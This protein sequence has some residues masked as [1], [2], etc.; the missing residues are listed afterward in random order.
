MES[1]T[2]DRQAPDTASEVDPERLEAFLHR[3]VGDMAATAA[4]ALTLTGHRLGLFRAMAGAGPLTSEELAERTGLRE[5]YL[6]EWL[7]AQAAGAYVTYDAATGRYTLPPEQAAALADSDSPVFVAGGFDVLA[8]IW[9]A[10]ERMAEAFRTGEGVGWH[11]HDARLFNGTEAFFRPGYKANLASAWIPALEGVEEKLR[12]GAKVADVG[13]GHG[14]STIIMAEAFPASMFYGFDYHGPSIETAGRRA[15]DAG[16]ADRVR[17]EVAPATAFPGAGYDLIC[18]FDCFHDLGDP[19]GAAAHARKAL[20]ADGTLMLV[21]PMA[22]DRPEENLHPLGRLFYA[23]STFLCTPNSLSQEVGTA[24]GAQA[25][26]AR[27]RA[28]LEEAGF[29]RVRRATE[30]PFNLILEARP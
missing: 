17:F 7:N 3:A 24:L 12:A 6:R 9:A 28:I 21:E 2:I 5:R 15:S 16:V 14:A 20:A 13:C 26:E 4:C 29:R 18:F 19:V 8:A 23:A 11:E 30:T 22:G 10:T 27:L 1:Q 25:G